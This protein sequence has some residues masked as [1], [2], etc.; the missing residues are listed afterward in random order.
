MERQDSSGKWRTS[1]YCS[2]P[3]LVSRRM[4]RWKEDVQGYEFALCATT[5]DPMLVIVPRMVSMDFFAVLAW[6]D[7][8]QDDTCSVPVWRP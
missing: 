1:R 5:A 3:H 4:S 2:I 7:I 6:Q 8:K